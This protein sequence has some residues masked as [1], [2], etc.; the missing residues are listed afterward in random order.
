MYVN[1]VIEPA[2]SIPWITFHEKCRSK[3]RAPVSGLLELLRRKA[4]GTPSTCGPSLEGYFDRILI[5][6]RRP[7]RKEAK[8][9]TTK[10]TRRERLRQALDQ[11]GFD[12]GLC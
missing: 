4:K 2:D 9:G 1:D 12:T 11:R 7:L 5:Q 3:P 6:P 8:P 10:E